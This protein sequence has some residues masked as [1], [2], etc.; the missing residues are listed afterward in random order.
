MY[1]RRWTLNPDALESARRSVR[2]LRI[3]SVGDS[4]RLA[5]GEI[6]LYPLGN[7]ST[8]TAIGAWLPQGRFFWA[9]DYVQPSAIS[10]Y[11]RDVVATIRALGLDPLKVGAQHVPLTEW[12][13]L[14]ARYS[15]R[16]P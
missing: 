2:K 15:M 8:E 1:A 4:L 13:A 10:P 3:R 7:T 9:G 5:G 16:Q 14:S 11:A 12:A 6:V